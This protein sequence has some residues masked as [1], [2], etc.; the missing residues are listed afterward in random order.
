MKIWMKDEGFLMFDKEKTCNGGK[1]RKSDGGI[2][3]K[4]GQ[5][6]LGCVD[7][8]RRDGR[9]GGEPASSIILPQ[10]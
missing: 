1:E 5:P 3:A 9:R 4:T 10:T 7:L 2:K 8:Y 6:P